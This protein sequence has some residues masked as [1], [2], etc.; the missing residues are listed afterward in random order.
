[1]DSLTEVYQ[2]EIK[3]EWVDYNSHLNDAYYALVF[4]L[5]G[6]ALYDALGLGEQWRQQQNRTIFTLDARTRYLREVHLG[7]K[8]TI[9]AQL[10]ASDSRRMHFLLYMYADDG[11]V[12][13]A[14]SEQVVVCIDPTVTRA[15]AFDTDAQQRISDL[16]QQHLHAAKPATVGRPLGL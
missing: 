5:A 16:L 4:S 14:T 13:R 9:K 15:A 3:P 11:K 7:A 8:L 6:E 1:M 2:C 10:L 12:L